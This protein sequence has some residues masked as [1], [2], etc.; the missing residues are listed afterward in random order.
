LRKS[1]N[2]TVPSQSA[3]TSLTMSVAMS[4]DILRPAGPFM[5][6]RSS[7]STCAA[8][9]HA[10]AAACGVSACSQQQVGGSQANAACDQT[11]GH[12]PDQTCRGGAH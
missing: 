9:K 7:C 3:S 4:R 11:V 1:S 8:V 5:V 6:G 10:A 2:P 12:T